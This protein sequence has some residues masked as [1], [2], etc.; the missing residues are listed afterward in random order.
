MSLQTIAECLNLAREQLEPTGGEQL[1]ALDLWLRQR[2][3]V[4]LS[5]GIVQSEGRR[6]CMVTAHGQTFTAS[7]RGEGFSTSWLAIVDALRLCE[8]FEAA[9][10]LDLR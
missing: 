9:A 5:V 4:W 6:Q 7:R 2:G 10:F 8:Q 1:Q 3:D